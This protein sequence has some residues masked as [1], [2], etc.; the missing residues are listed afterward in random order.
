MEKKVKGMTKRADQI[1][2]QAAIDALAEDMP[3]TYTPDGSH[4][5]DDDIFLAQEIYA[6]CIQRLEDLPSAEPES[7]TDEEQ[8]IFLSAMERE[9]KVCRQVDEEWRNMREP[10]EDSLVHVCNEIVRKVKGALWI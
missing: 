3:Q 1:Y 5:A 4:Y 2:R 10:Y 9:R 7:L 6:D 8:R